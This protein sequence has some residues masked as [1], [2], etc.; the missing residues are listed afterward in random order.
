MTTH[1]CPL[2]AVR[3]A[4][5]WFVASIVSPNTNSTAGAIRFSTLMTRE[6]GPT[7]P[8]ASSISSF[9]GGRS[10]S[11]SGIIFARPSFVRFRLS[12]HLMATSRS[13]TTKALIQPALAAS[14]ALLCSSLNLTR[15]CSR[16]RTPLI[17]PSSA[18]SSIFRSALSSA[19]RVSARFF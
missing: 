16:P 13:L 1:L 5:R 3:K 6:T 8:G 12:T 18:I 9:S 10:R 15:S 4:A 14:I 7:I 11:S 2:A 19:W 17:A